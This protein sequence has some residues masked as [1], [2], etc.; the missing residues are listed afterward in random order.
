[1]SVLLN[2]N[3]SFDP[4]KDNFWVLNP[5]IKIMKPFSELYKRDD[6][7]NKDVSSREMWCIMFLEE[8]NKEVNTFANTP[9]EE[10][11]KILNETYFPLDLED[12]LV[13]R[14]VDAYNLHL[15][16]LAAKAFKS[17]EESLLERGR[18]INSTPYT[19]DSILLDAKGNQVIAAGRPVLQKG[20]ARDLDTL[21]KNT[22]SIFEQY[23]KVEAL[24]LEELR[25][26]RIHGGRTEN[27][28]EKGQLIKDIDRS[29]FILEDD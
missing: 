6:S 27:M 28:R 21:R 18:I 23:K 7:E 1:M 15:L 20:T 25:N 19:F 10:K 26:V 17:E 3:K 9:R 22:L 13:D 16:T 24:F 5:Q 14:C 29:K 2:L 12:D 11:V 8:P 4:I